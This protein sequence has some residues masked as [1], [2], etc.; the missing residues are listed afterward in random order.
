M[1]GLSAALAT[2]ILARIALFPA[3]SS[4][5][6]V[7]V[8]LVVVNFLIELQALIWLR[9]SGVLSATYIPYACA[10]LFTVTFVIL[11]LAHRP[12]G[13]WPQ[14]RLSASAVKKIILASVGFILNIILVVLYRSWRICGCG[15]DYLS[16]LPPSSFICWPI[17]AGPLAGIRIAGLFM[18]FTGECYFFHAAS[19]TIAQPSL[20][21]LVHLSGFTGLYAVVALNFFNQSSPRSRHN[22]PPHSNAALKEF[23][24]VVVVVPT[25]GE[26]IEVLEKTVIS[27]RRLNYPADRYSVIVSDDGHRSEVQAMAARRRAYYNLGPRKDAKA[28]NLNSALKFIA[29]RFPQAVLVLTQDAD[30]IIHPDFLQKTVGYFLENERLGFVQTPKEALAPRNDPFGTRDRMFYDVVQVGRNGFGAAFACGSGVL[31]RIQAVRAIG[32]FSTWNVVE[33][34]TTSYYLHAAGWEVRVSR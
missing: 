4:P 33:D 1:L 34:L 12:L 17:S 5:T 8:A 20:L 6:A 24:F 22:R 11:A 23:P 9:A 32:G 10:I 16:P 7:G 28:G 14:V 31:W 30:E 27:L 15:A 29:R 26:P 21:A 18:L 2:L 19:M 13:L 25:Y 3:W